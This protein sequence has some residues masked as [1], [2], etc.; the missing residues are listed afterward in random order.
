[1][2]ELASR[3][4]RVAALRPVAELVAAVSF[5]T[6]I[7]VPVGAPF[8]R[9]G[10]AAFG[11]VGVGLGLLAA[12][13]VAL[14]GAAH[15]WPAALVALAVLAI[16]DGG[17]HLDGLADTA[18]ALAA[19]SGAADRA[20]TDPRSGSAGLV[21]VVL[22]L[23]LQAAAIAELAVRGA[24]VAG[25]AIVVAVTVSRAAAPVWAVT[26]G[27]A[28]DGGDGLGRWFAQRTGVAA[29]GLAAAT[30]AVVA[31]VAALV[32]GPAL[33]AGAAAGTASAALVGLGVLRLRGQLD[34][35]GYGALIEIAV[36]AVL[37]GAA[38]AA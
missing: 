16:L 6:R 5:L 24:L 9:T 11:L 29:A 34:G 25:T 12:V 8:A 35:D 13:P 7:P 19:P 27:G 21:A 10:A 38:V 3:A 36:A 26:A 15:P 22:V 2:A 23:G 31:V 37:L 28:M 1:M 33:V 18:D 4:A 32:G 14:A 17:L 20:R 30:A